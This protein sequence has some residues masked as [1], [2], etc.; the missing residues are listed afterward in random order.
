[1]KEGQLI[2]QILK[3]DTASFEYFVDTYQH[4]ALTIAYRL[5]RNRTDAE[6]VVQDS[7]VKAYQNL[8]TFRSDGKFSTWFYR[9]VYNTGITHV[10]KKRNKDSL[11]E[12]ENRSEALK[13]QPVYY[14]NKEQEELRS[15]IDEALLKLPQIEAVI[16]SLYYLEA[17]S[18]KEITKIVSLTESNVKIKLFRARNKLKELINL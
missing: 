10:N 12:T 13:V 14:E 8:H 7:Y 17:Y 11:L 18:I 6:D 9:I 3:G 2:K 5:C 4:M 16:V 15:N 1:M